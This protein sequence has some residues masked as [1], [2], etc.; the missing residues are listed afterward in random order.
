MNKQMINMTG[1]KFG[2][3]IVKEWSFKRGKNQ[4]WS[5][6]CDCG[7]IKDVNGTDLRH[8]KI[9][10]CGCL[11]SEK[12]RIKMYKHGMSNHRFYKIWTSMKARVLNKNN[13]DYKY[14]GGKGI[15]ICVDWMKF[16]KFELDMYES[17]LEHCEK[18]GIKETTIDRID[19]DGNYELNNCKW[20]TWIEQATNRNTTHFIEV[21]ECKLSMRQAA[22]KYNLTYSTLASRLQR[23]WTAEECI[24]HI[25]YR[26]K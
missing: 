10:S 18:I 16:E 11:K 1:M 17:Y 12:M 15:K 8:G 9:K 25:G 21:D 22:R 5:C 7:V 2:R 19:T 23:G 6:E 4:F 13:Y 14:Y 26:R 20:S 24:K 3:L